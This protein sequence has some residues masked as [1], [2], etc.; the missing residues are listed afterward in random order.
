MRHSARFGSRNWIVS[1]DEWLPFKP[2][3][4]DGAI[5]CLNAHWI[6]NLKRKYDP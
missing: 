6:E 2:K 5:S 3:S 1:D 4:F